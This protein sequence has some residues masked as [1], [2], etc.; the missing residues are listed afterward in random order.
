MNQLHDHIWEIYSK[1]FEEV[2]CPKFCGAFTAEEIRKRLKSYNLPVSRQDVFIRNVPIQIDLLIHRPK[3]SVRYHGLMY[4]PEDVLAVLEIKYRGTFS[5]DAIGRIHDNFQAIQRANKAI[6][7]FYLTVVETRGYKNAVT[8]QKL[9][10]PAYTLYWYGK[11]RYKGTNAW[12]KL[13]MR[14]KK[15]VSTA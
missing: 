12:N 8:S 10:Y 13:V 4:E 15:K 1:A 2:S 3:A 14:L 6:A 11:G 9:G 5:A 7:C